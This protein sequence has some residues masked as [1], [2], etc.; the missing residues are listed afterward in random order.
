M[1]LNQAVAA[2]GTNAWALSEKAKKTPTIYLNCGATELIHGELS[3][4]YSVDVAGFGFTAVFSSARP[5]GPSWPVHP[6]TLT[7]M[8]RL[9]SRVGASAL[10]TAFCLITVGRL[11]AQTTA[12]P[13]T[14]KPAD[15][16]TIVLSPFVVEATEDQGYTAKDTLAGTR[17]RTELKDVSS[18]ISVV[19]KQFLQDTGTHNAQDLLVYTPNTEVAGLRGNYS[20]QG[21]NITYSEPLTNPNNTTRVR[22]LESADNTRDYFLTDIPFDAFNV[23]R[24]DL[25][26]GPNSIL[27]GVG[28]PAGIIN[29]SL[30]G[31]SFKNSNKVENSTSQYGSERNLVDFNYVVMPNQ[32][33][34]RLAAVSD[35]QKYQQEGAFNNATRFYGAL[36][37]DPKI[38]N[39]E[40]SHTSFRANYENGSV[41]SDNPRT[42]PPDDQ[43]TR[44][45]GT[46]TSAGGL[47]KN[48]INEY[49]TGQGVSSPYGNANFNQGWALGRVY[50]P[51]P[52]SYYNGSDP[53]HPGTMP[54]VLSGTPSYVS[55]GEI[56][57]GWAIN[58]AGNMAPPNQPG[59]GANIGIGGLPNYQLTAIPPYSHWAAR[60]LPGGTYYANKVLTDPSVF[61]FYG[62]LLDGPNKREWQ[63]WNAYNLNLSQT[64][65]NDRV[66]IELAYDHQIYSNGQVGF[67]GGENYGI[68][69]DVNQTLANGSPNPNLGRPY[70][71]NASESGN[72][73][74]RIERDSSR[75]TAFGDI[76]AEDFMGKTTLAKIIGRHVLTGLLALDHKEQTNV[77]W[78]QY[79]TDLDWERLNNFDT[80]IK[81]AN[82]RLNNWV[83]YI[84][85]SLGGASSAAGAKLTSI[86]NI[87]APGKNTNVTWF[88]SHWNHSLIPG[89]PGYVNPA[90]TAAPS[91]TDGSTP[92]NTWINVGG[93]FYNPQGYYAPG[94]SPADAVATPGTPIYSYLG[95]NDGLE[96]RTSQN[97][98]PANYVGW[99]TVPVTWMNANNKDDFPSLV[100]GGSR[101]KFRDTSKALIWQ[102]YFLDGDLVGTYGWRKDSITNFATGA[103]IDSI[104]SVA[105][106]NYTDDPNSRRVTEGQTRTWGGV[107]HLPK[108]I[109]KHLPGDSGISFIYNQG[110]NFKADAPRTNFAGQQIPNPDGQT[111][112]YG[113][114]LS[115]LADKITLKVIKYE[116]TVHWGT[117]NDNALGGLGGNGYLLDLIPAWGWGYA[118]QVQWGLDGHFGNTTLGGPGDTAGGTSWNYVARDAIIANASADLSVIGTPAGAAT[119]PVA[120][121]GYGGTGAVSMTDIVN[122]WIHMPIPDNFF[123]FFGIT[124]NRP[125]PVKT[126]STGKLYQGFS[127]PF[128][129]GFE[130]VGGQQ[131]SGA[132][133]TVSTVDNVSNGWEYELSAQPIKNWNITVNYSRT[134]A[135]KNNIDAITQKFMADNLAF[136][137]GPGGQL[138]LWGASQTAGY[139]TNTNPTGLPTYPWAPGQD[140]GSTVATKWIAG[141]YNPYLV[142]ALAQGQSAPEVSPWRFNLITTYNFDRG[143]AR[144]AFAGGAIRMEAGRI[145]GYRLNPTTLV[146]DVKQVLVGPTDTHYDLWVGYSKKFEL[147]KNINWRIQLNLRD[148]GE[149]SHLVAARYEPDGTLALARIQQGMTWQLTN[150]FEF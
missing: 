13:A 85:P 113:I 11:A 34:V 24:V 149:K 112:E 64:F 142:T 134:E 117:L 3:R 6:L 118:A 74:T 33:A 26:R 140:N 30:N 47:S 122:A 88:D 82:Y 139:G 128:V 37:F 50:W 83:Y 29:T 16:E 104:T 133:N 126:R 4:P 100:T 101:S 19:T 147:G 60:N 31:A 103:P 108:F 71:A 21:G 62:K 41:K 42:I 25:Q 73:S 57:T 8:N 32:L 80:S 141:V 77:S 116:T 58:S 87:I 10:T 138:R 143:V 55:I 81:V 94:H 63:N 44:W 43:I 20:G 146:L 9:L 23:G 38:F 2:G 17:V 99:R 111:K 90:A 14:T 46:N 52:V 123:N 92:G 67:L 76:R 70:V 69:I 129:N 51:T 79:A 106:L 7:T 135:T 131:P 91:A 27:F 110:R 89:S 102:G 36:R 86:Q 137:Q 105:A 125:D 35:K 12:A 18:S 75:A 54:A 15:E 28:S 144:G 45:F 22:G 93:S 124:G 96:N 66:G 48:T 84:G 97:N 40:G 132:Q 49:L 119:K 68:N 114:A 78:S 145:L 95:S 115:T 98:N 120:T 5:A 107:Y 61:D 53:A 109:M 148:V 130:G 72:S 39:N 65:L 1:M 136:Y 150:T 56:G 127:T 59:N 121:Y